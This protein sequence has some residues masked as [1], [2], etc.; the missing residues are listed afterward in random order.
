VL[1]TSL[2][3]DLYKLLLLIKVIIAFNWSNT[4]RVDIFAFC[5]SVKYMHQLFHLS[6]LMFSPWLEAAALFTSI[7]KV[8]FYFYIPE[9]LRNISASA[10]LLLNTFVPLYTTTINCNYLHWCNKCFLLF[11]GLIPDTCILDISMGIYFLLI[12][13]SCW[14]S[15]FFFHFTT[16]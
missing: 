4:W 6:C 10:V 14:L 13:T 3:W 5:N 2:D 16:F 8:F 11:T 7:R 15:P 9:R 1:I 12:T